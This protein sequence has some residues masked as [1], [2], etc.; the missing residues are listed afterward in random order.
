MG[1]YPGVPQGRSSEPHVPSVVSVPSYTGVPAS[2]HTVVYHRLVVVGT[3]GKGYSGFPEYTY[4]YQAVAGM[5]QGIPFPTVP[6]TSTAC[7]RDPDPLPSVP[8][9][10]MV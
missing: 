5:P 2:E 3:G 9:L 10:L 4:R 6:L 7:P 1:E 8:H